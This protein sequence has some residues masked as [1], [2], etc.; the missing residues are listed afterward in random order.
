MASHVGKIEWKKIEDIEKLE[1]LPGTKKYFPICHP[2][3]V[4]GS[5]KVMD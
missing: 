2:E 1:I 4:S 3:L 5:S